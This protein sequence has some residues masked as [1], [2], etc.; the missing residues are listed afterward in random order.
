M[1]TDEPSNS[2]LAYGTTDIYHTGNEQIISDSSF[3]TY[4]SIPLTNLQANTR[5]HY[6][7]ESKDAAGNLTI[8]GSTF[9]D[10]VSQ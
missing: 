10:T 1:K 2:Q 4:H 6:R 7:V 5:Y 8:S 9:F 3:V